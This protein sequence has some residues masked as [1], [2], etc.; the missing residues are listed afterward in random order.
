MATV[1]SDLIFAPDANY[2]PYHFGAALNLGN[3][4]F[5]PTVVTEMFLLR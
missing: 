4:T 5:A 2:P 1:L 3:G